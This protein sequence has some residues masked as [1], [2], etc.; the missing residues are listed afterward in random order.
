MSV[1]VIITGNSRLPGASVREMVRSRGVRK[2]WAGSLWQRLAVKLDFE[3]LWDREASP[4]KQCFIPTKSTKSGLQ[5]QL[6]VGLPRCVDVYS[7]G[8]F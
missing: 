3:V 1:A 8:V 7:A 2:G 4:A 5:S 6:C